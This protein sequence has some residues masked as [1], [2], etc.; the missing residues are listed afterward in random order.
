M[1]W[2]VAE[3][4]LP[5]TDCTAICQQMEVVRQQMEGQDPQALKSEMDRL[6]DLTRSLAD[7]V[8]GQAVLSALQ[9]Q[10]TT[11]V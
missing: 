7:T 1:H 8:M 11:P 2:T 3:K 5:P 4:A 6:G 10:E 9:E